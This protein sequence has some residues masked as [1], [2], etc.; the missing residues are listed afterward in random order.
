MAHEKRQAGWSQGT[1]SR[2]GRG[3]R[4]QKKVG[5]F[6]LSEAGNRE[7]WKALE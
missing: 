5:V 6:R 1:M 2:A 3:M 7:P 4:P